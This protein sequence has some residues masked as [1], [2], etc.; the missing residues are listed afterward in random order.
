MGKSV[1][2]FALLVM[3]IGLYVAYELF[4][5]WGVTRAYVPPG[6]SLIVN[7]STGA[8]R[9]P[10]QYAQPG[11]KGL[12]EQM[13]GPGR[14]FGLNPWFVSTTRQEDKEVKP[15]QIRIVSNKYGKT[16]PPGRFIAKPDEQGI[17]EAVLTPGVWR[18]N[19]KGQEVSEP[20]SAD[21]I[22]TM[23]HTGY[24]GVQT[25]QEGENK[26]ILDRV[27]SAGYYNLNPKYVKIDLVDIGYKV[28]EK[29]VDMETV[30]V[31]TLDGKKTQAQRAVLGTGVAFT[32]ADGKMM[33]LDITVVWGIFPED[34]PSVCRNY[35]SD[36]EIIAKVIE[37]QVLSI[38]KNAGANLTTQQ[39]IE[40][41]TREKFQE[42]VTNSL[43]TIGEQKKIRFRDALIRGF[44]PDE[45]IKASIQARRL[46]EEERLT[47]AFE[48]ERDT[49]S[50]QL[51]QAKKMVNIAVT[52]YDGETTALVQKEM[53]MG[54]KKAAET[55]AQADRQAA[56]LARQTAEID[57]QA[58]LISGKAEA[59]VIELTKK[60]EAAP[61]ELQVQIFGSPEAFTRA[62]FAE[63]LYPDIS[64]EYR[65][66]GPGTFWTDTRSD[67]KDLAAKVLM[68]QTQTQPA[69]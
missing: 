32:L 68:Q 37:P 27:L 33:Q 44:H 41:Q 59:E 1:K 28:W 26:G 22:H 61:L 51:V 34:A 65:Y 69:R 30:T 48:Q 46:A 5:V 47:L 66:A 57:A 16:P 11:Q 49:V 50:A 36:A 42:E 3:A 29:S 54:L 4:W 14:H 43:R 62:A 64:I 20:L 31:T 10:T 8:D 38:C 39:F 55:T 52:D 2:I 35:G 17:Q 18:I 7:R 23:I 24:V 13:L 63:K 45:A 19:E 58:T 25:M 21:E 12:L 56:Q 9:D 6:R 15:G 40:G 60:A 67:L 53:Q